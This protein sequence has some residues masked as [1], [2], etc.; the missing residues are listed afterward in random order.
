VLQGR[1][2]TIEVNACF[3]RDDKISRLKADVVYLK[4]EL[5]EMKT[6]RKVNG[7]KL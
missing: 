7:D 2:H 1:E 6:G 5:A 3:H 4:A